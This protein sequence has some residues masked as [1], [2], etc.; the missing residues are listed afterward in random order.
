MNFTNEHESNQLA[1]ERFA[2]RARTNFSLTLPLGTLLVACRAAVPKRIPARGGRSSRAYRATSLCP[3]QFP[4]WARF[5]VVIA[6]RDAIHRSAT[7]FDSSHPSDP[8]PNLLRPAS[9]HRSRAPRR[10]NHARRSGS[11]R[12]LRRRAI[13][14]M[15]AQG[16]EQR[17][18]QRA[19]LAR[20]DVRANMGRPAHA[21][22]HHG[23][24]G[25]RQNEP[26]R[27]LGQR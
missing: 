9:A 12:P 8:C 6:R 2:Q 7:R 14:A 24:V 17:G 25:V 16:G 4:V 21:R 15:L 20:R 11:V 19:F 5:Q 27:Q 1:R 18:W 26:K 13:P 10:T 22:N 3:L 23:H